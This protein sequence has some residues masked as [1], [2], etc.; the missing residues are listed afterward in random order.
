[1]ANGI[2]ATG[3][4]YPVVPKGDEEIRFQIA[5]D[6]TEKDIDYVLEVLKRFKGQQDAI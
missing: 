2:L 1:T 5:A 6:H 3:L 4:N